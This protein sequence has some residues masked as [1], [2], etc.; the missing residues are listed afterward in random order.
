[1]SSHEL[2]FI[3]F[4]LKRVVKKISAHLGRHD[5]G[6]EIRENILISNDCDPPFSISFGEVSINQV[7]NPLSKQVKCINHPA[8]R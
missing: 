6:K 3:V 8:R 2:T 1:M 5:A 4:R 7:Q